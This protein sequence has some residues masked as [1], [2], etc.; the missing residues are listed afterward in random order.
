MQP[1]G[2][3]RR[4]ACASAA[5]SVG[6]QIITVVGDRSVNSVAITESSGFCTRLAYALEAHFQ[7]ADQRMN[8]WWHKQTYK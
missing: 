4:Y 2:F 3:G 7:T 5:R 8:F 6:R 1:N